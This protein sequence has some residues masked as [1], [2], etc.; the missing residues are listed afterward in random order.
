MQVCR[1]TNYLPLNTGRRVPK[2][3]RQAVMNPAALQVNGSQYLL[4]KGSILVSS[5]SNNFRGSMPIY[6]MKLKISSRKFFFLS[7]LIKNFFLI[8]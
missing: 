4:R 6:P 3:T 1:E 2:F 5:R 8:N 7:Q